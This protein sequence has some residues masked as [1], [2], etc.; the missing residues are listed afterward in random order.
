MFKTLA[1]FEN[2]MVNDIVDKLDIKLFASGVY[3]RS[4]NFDLTTYQKE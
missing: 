1:E 2:S 3:A 4:D